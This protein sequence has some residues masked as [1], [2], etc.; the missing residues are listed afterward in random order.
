M[1]ADLDI[2]HIESRQGFADQSGGHDSGRTI[3]RHL[4]W[5]LLL[6][7]LEQGEIELARRCYRELLIQNPTWRQTDFTEIG[8]LISSANHRAALARLK[9]IR[10][11]AYLVSLAQPSDASRSNV[12]VRTGADIPEVIGLKLDL[13]A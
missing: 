8:T 7:A 4:P 3:V 6:D 12:I 10:S 11:P 2:H 1:S 5:Q 13:K 9:A